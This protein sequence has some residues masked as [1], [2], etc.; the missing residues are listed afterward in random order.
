MEIKDIT[1][2]IH[3]QYEHVKSNQFDQLTV[4]RERVYPVTNPN[5]A[6]LI[7]VDSPEKLTWFDHANESL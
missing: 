7:G 5:T 6:S 1:E 3:Q 4:A 2:F